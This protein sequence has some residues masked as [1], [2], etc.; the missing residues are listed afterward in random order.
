MSLFPA[1]IPNNTHLY[2]GTHTPNAVKGMEWLAF[3]IEHAEMFARASPGRRPG[4]K[5]GK[6]GDP[7][8]PER[9][10][11]PGEGP[12]PSPFELA[13]A[14]TVDG[15]QSMDDDDDEPDF[16]STTR[17]IC[18]RLVLALTRSLGKGVMEMDLEGFIGNMGMMVRCRLWSYRKAGEGGQGKMG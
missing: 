10:G 8:R 3:E 13:W 15:I 2:H 17:P 6:P 4:R 18:R 7:E 12:P 16:S 1:R 11:E 5:P 9:P 14:E